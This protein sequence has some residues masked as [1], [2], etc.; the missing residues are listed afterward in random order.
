MSNEQP[1]PDSIPAPVSDDLNG[2]RRQVAV[3]HT[4]EM[5]WQASPSA[6][7]WRKRLERI[8][9]QEAGV[10]TSVVRYD[11]GSRFSEHWHPDGEEFFVL[12]GIFEDEHGRYPAGS[13]VLNPDGTHH[14]PG[15]TEGCTLFVKLRQYAG[16]GR[17]RLVC[18]STALDWQPGG[19]PGHQVKP[20]YRQAGFPEEVRLATLEPGT[21]VEPHDHPGGE[22]VFVLEGALSDEAGHYPAGSWMRFPVGSRH[23]PWSEDGCLLFV[24][25]GGLP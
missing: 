21:R 14:A 6:G 2:D 17:R 8:G 19:G 23:A 12:E 5:D 24:R 11:A 9:P 1:A 22:E 7:V 25:T 10:V 20:L 3:M 16:S 4:A 15:T 18:D 13:Y